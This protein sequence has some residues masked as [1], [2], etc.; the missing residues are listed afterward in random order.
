MLKEFP[1]VTTGM[2]ACKG[3]PVRIHV[4]NSITPVAQPHRR[5]P[6]HVRKQ[7]EEKLIQLEAADII[8]RAEGPTPWISPIVV[9]PKPHNPDEIRICV[10]MRKVNRAIV[11]E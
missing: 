11:R 8:E 10:D 6:F 7:V 9:V 5:I 2:G 1:T 3:E 4:D